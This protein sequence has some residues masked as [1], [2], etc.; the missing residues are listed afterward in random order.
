MRPLPEQA[1]HLPFDGGPYRMAM[2]LVTVAESRWFEFDRQDLPEMA[3]KR[4]LLTNAHG[5]V[6]AAASA[7]DDARAEALELIVTAL[8][9][10]HPDG[11]S[12]DGTVLRNHLTGECWESRSGA[13]LNQ[14][15]ASA[16]A[17]LSV[18]LLK[19]VM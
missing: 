18:W 15:G 3:E 9:N 13:R 19:D 14:T 12:R 16:A 10:H 17:P 2:D 1:V 7:S 5:E 11:F 8:T 6:F 4:R